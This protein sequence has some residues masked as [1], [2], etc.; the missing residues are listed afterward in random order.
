MF[1]SHHMTE[2]PCRFAALPH[3]LPPTK[4]SPKNDLENLSMHQSPLCPLLVPL[5]WIG[6]PGHGATVRQEFANR[7]SFC[8]EALSGIRQ[9]QWEPPKRQEWQQ[10]RKQQHFGTFHSST[11]IHAIGDNYMLVVLIIKII[12]IMIMMIIIIIIII[13]IIARYGY[14]RLEI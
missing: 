10:E 7:S 5:A 12:I 9:H 4:K 1:C 3:Q 11:S 6:R 2:K 8:L 14:L 13:I